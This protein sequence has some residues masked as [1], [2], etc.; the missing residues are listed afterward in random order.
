MVKTIP[1]SKWRI[2]V[3]IQSGL[4][5]L[6]LVGFGA[7]AIAQNSGQSEVKTTNSGN[8]VPGML[9]TAS[10]KATPGTTSAPSD[11]PSDSSDGGGTPQMDVKSKRMQDEYAQCVAVMN[12]IS[13]KIRELTEITNSYNQQLNNFVPTPYDPA[14]SQAEMNAIWAA[15]EARRQA[16]QTQMDAAN[17]AE[18]A[19]EATTPMADGSM[20]CGSG[21]GPYPQ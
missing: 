6:V 8:L 7:I 3:W 10:P 19:Y 4:L 13:Q 5:A 1:R 20:S 14:L 9:L 2:F 12:Q 15:D 17:A 21:N 11:A 16:I 18:H